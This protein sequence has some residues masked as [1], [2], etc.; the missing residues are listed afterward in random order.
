MAKR[1]PEPLAGRGRRVG[2]WTV[3]ERVTWGDIYQGK[4]VRLVSNI[5]TYDN[6]VTTMVGEANDTNCFKG[7]FEG[8]GCSLT[9]KYEATEA[10]TAPFRYARK[11]TF[12]N[13]KIKGT[14]ETSFNYTAGLI[15]DLAGDSTIDNCTSS[16]EIKVTKN[17][18]G[19]RPVCISGFVA[20]AI[21][22]SDKLTFQDCLFDGKLLNSPDSLEPSQISGFV[23]YVD[24]DYAYF[25]DC[26]FNPAEVG[27]YKDGYAGPFYGY[28]G[29]KS[30]ERHCNGSVWV[31]AYGGTSQGKDG[32]K[33]TQGF[34]SLDDLP[35]GESA[36]NYEQ[37]TKCGTDLYVKK[38]TE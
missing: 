22:K 19:A 24:Y 33:C 23:G 17:E 30:L 9:V 3:P 4:Y 10:N 13:L 7:T 32:S 5:G 37:V 31:T 36:D 26:L 29:G 1:Q 27:T 2:D 12:K 34:I 20:S 35:E 6:P 28:S 38:S 11:V 21:S 14:I 8:E 16:V 25:Y 18:S 15:A